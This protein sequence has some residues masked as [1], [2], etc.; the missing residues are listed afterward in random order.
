MST[1]ALPH[2]HQQSRASRRPHPLVAVIAWELRRYRVS[3]LFGLQALGFFGIV[4]FVTWVSQ[5]PSQ[6]NLGNGNVVLIGFVAGTSAWGLLLTLPTGV[7]LLFGLLLPFVNADGVSR[8]F[9]RRTHELLMTTPLPSGAYVWGR[10]LVGMLM[11]LGLALL[12]LAAI[13]GVGAVLHLTDPTY[14]SPEIGPVLLLWVGMVVTATVVVSSLS[15]ALGTV[16]PRQSTLVKVVIMMAWFIAALVLPAGG[17]QTGSWY[18]NWDPTSATTALG[19]LPG[20]Q[21]A[22]N[23]LLHAATSAAEFQQDLVAIENHVANISAWL[24]PH[25]ILAACSLLLVLLAA[26]SFH[27]F[28]GALS[29][30]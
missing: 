2:A 27:R 18:V 21:A 12:L 1:I 9:S 30:S 17:G 6:F 4:L 25:L 16:F 22:F 24:A 10:Y 28:R 14:P 3:R 8:D 20:Y 29:A 26:L 15:F 11:S 23:K 7:L 13:L 5:M 19:M